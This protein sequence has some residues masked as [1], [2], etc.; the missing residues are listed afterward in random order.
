LGA[1]NRALHKPIIGFSEAFHNM[2]SDAS[3]T[4]RD[5]CRRPI[6]REW[7]EQALAAGTAPQPTARRAGNWVVLGMKRSAK[8]ARRE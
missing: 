4:D 2:A 3:P 7:L 5:G 1:S 8:A 6:S